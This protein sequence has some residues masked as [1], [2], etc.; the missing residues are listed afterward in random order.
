MRIH[1]RARSDCCCDVSALAG[2]WKFMHGCAY[3]RAEATSAIRQIRALVG[4]LGCAGDRTQNIRLGVAQRG[5]LG[6]QVAEHNGGDVRPVT[7]P[8][9]SVQRT[10]VSEHNPAV[11]Y[12]SPAMGAFAEGNALA[13]ASICA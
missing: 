12:G 9:M 13:M 2:S 8:L 3:M 5:R 7:A 10:T 4:P 6:S 1:K 11:R